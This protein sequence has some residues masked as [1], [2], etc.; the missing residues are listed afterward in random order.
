[1]LVPKRHITRFEEL[2]VLEGAELLSLI[3]KV[4][5]VFKRRYGIADYILLQKNGR[6]AGQTVSHSHVHAFPCPADI[7]YHRVFDHKEPMTQEE[8]R[9]KAEDLKPYFQ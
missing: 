8:M 7:D 3:D 5:D 2:D 1:M 6:K 9:Q 4:Q